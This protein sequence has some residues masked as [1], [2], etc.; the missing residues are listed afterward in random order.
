M[1]GAVFVAGG[2]SVFE[3][4]LLLAAA[5]YPDI[6]FSSLLTV[7]ASGLGRNFSG[8]TLTAVLDSYMEALQA[9]FA[10]GT[11]IAGVAVLAS[12]L[13]PLKSIRGTKVDG[14]VAEDG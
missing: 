7:G 3:N 8:P 12:F 11:A 4:R 10:F 2:Q 14:G 6:D 5:N 13:A 1:G 9:T